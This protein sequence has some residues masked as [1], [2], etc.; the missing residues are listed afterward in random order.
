MEDLKDTDKPNQC[1]SLHCLEWHLQQRVVNQPHFK[2]NQFSRHHVD[3]QEVKPVLRKR[4]EEK[5]FDG[6]PS[7]AL[8][9]WQA[10]TRKEK[11]EVNV[12]KGQRKRSRAIAFRSHGKIFHLPKMYFSVMLHWKQQDIVVTISFIK[13]FPVKTKVFSDNFIVTKE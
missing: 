6:L 3:Q 13:L 9:S 7:T 5:Q 8:E 4:P 10:W 12:L 11:L 2:M 1:M